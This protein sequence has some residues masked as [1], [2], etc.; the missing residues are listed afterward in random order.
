MGNIDF[1]YRKVAKEIEKSGL[2][3]T[4]SYIPNE[5]AWTRYFVLKK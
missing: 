1:P 4:E 3:I 2:K 5:S